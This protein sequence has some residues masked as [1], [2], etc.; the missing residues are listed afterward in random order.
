MA[1]GQAAGT[2]AG[3]AVKSGCAPVAV[4]IA[5]LQQELEAGG[6]ILK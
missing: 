6:A 1:T 4:D 3:I 5:Q 2:A